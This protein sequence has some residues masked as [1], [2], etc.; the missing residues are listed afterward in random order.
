[1][2]NFNQNEM[3]ISNK[4]VI[5]KTMFNNLSS[6]MVTLKYKG[7]NK[8]S[9]YHMIYD[10]G[11]RPKY[12]SFASVVKFPEFRILI[13]LSTLIQIASY[14]DLDLDRVEDNPKIKYW[15]LEYYIFGASAGLVVLAFYSD[16]I[17]KQNM[18]FLPIFFHASLLFLLFVGT[19]IYNFL[20]AE[21]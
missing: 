2:A 9:I 19:Y 7:Q 16:C 11:N 1:M 4:M 15:P 17:F 14:C 6:Q 20:V 5:N 13:L 18:L 10:T 21:I 3:S 8:K 12:F